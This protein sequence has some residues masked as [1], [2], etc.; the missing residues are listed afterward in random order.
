MGAFGS[1]PPKRSRVSRVREAVGR[2]TGS[3]TR[4]LSKGARVELGQ[5]MKRNRKNP[6]VRQYMRTTVK[7]LLG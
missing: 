4:M 6:E 1:Q 3:F 7:K 5:R 2:T